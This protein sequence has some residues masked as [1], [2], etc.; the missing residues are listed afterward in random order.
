MVKVQTKVLGL[1][2]FYHTMQ[3][4]IKL[5]APNKV[6][7]AMRSGA[8]VI[9]RKAQD[10]IRSNGLVQ[11]GLLLT[12]GKVQEGRGYSVEI[13]F[14]RV[15]AAAHE[16][17]LLKQPITE[18]QRRFFWFKFLEDGDPMWRALALSETYTI[19]ARPYLRPAIDSERVRAMRLAASVLESM[20]RQAVKR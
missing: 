12:S 20:I 16:Y 11:S 6:S 2:D 4:I 1:D 14:D 15:Y 7:V 17:G 19:P 10:N 9:L 8:D 3:R 13:V 5:T 18:R